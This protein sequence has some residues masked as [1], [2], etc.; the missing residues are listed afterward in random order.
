MSAAVEM[1]LLIRVACHL[2]LHKLPRATH[3]LHGDLFAYL[4]RE[5]IIGARVCA[6]GG[7]CM[8]GKTGLVTAVAHALSQHAMCRTHVVWIKCGEIETETLG[9]AKAHLLPLVSTCP[10][11][12]DSLQSLRSLTC[13]SAIQILDLSTWC[14]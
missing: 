5:V 14:K 10:S 1:T 13:I 6:D 3:Q 7:I 8:A 12:Q 11:S 4:K 9:K 2:N